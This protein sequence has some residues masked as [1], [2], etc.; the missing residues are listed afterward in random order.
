MG[1]M[2]DSSSRSDAISSSSKLARDGCLSRS[3]SSSTR[4]RISSKRRLLPP[5]RECFGLLQL[6][7]VELRTDV[8]CAE[9]RRSRLH[10]QQVRFVQHRHAQHL[11]DK[12]VD[13]DGSR[14]PPGTPHFPNSFDATRFTLVHLQVS[15]E[16]P[17]R[18]G[19]ST[20]TPCAA[21]PVPAM[22]AH[23]QSEALLRRLQRPR[24]NAMPRQHRQEHHRPLHAPAVLLRMDEV[25]LKGRLGTLIGVILTCWPSFT[26]RTC[27]AKFARLSIPFR[28][29]T[30]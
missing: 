21:W 5:F 16:F 28:S 25:H 10:R 29:S 12:S 26:S 11:L 24:S 19:V 15:A 8:M 30:S 9:L 6:G 13:A 4:P 23:R 20:P 27:R 18:G 17:V 7:L 14:F 2:F 1:R 22:I 3:I